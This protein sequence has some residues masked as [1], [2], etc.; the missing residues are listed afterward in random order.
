VLIERK[1]TPISKIDEKGIVELLIK[2]YRPNIH[3]N[4]PE[5]GKMSYFMEGLKVG[6][7]MAFE[8]PVGRF[9]YLGN[10]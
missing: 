9:R 4:Y 5:G 7:K 8:G 10:G 1:Y 2:V 3:P 6:D